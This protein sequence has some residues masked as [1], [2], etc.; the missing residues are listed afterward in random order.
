MYGKFDVSGSAGS[1]WR[2]VNRRR[3]DDQAAGHPE[4]GAERSGHTDAP[5]AMIAAN[6][7]MGDDDQ[8]EYEVEAIDWTLRTLEEIGHMIRAR[9]RHGWLVFRSEELPMG[10][11]AVTF[12][13]TRESQ[14]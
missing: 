9:K 12:R 6:P 10:T 1:H 14:A 7:V 3:S 5:D 11:T 8:Y 13:R 2:G 4:G